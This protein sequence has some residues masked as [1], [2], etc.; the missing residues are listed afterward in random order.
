MLL[1]TNKEI[2]SVQVNRALRQF[3]K[4][5]KNSFLTVQVYEVTPQFELS[6]P[7]PLKHTDLRAQS[8]PSIVL[9]TAL[10]STFFRLEGQAYSSSQR[11]NSVSCRQH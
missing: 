10:R 7:L 11:L 9:P 8:M 1:K 4:I 2:F 5:F 6:S 3:K